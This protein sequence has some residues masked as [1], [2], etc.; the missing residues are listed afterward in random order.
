LFA[1]HDTANGIALGAGFASNPV[2]KAYEKPYSQGAL[3]DLIA[4]RKTI[5]E[6]LTTAR[7]ATARSAAAIDYLRP[8]VTN[9]G[10]FAREGRIV[11]T[12]PVRAD[13][14]AALRAL[15]ARENTGRH[16]KT[17]SL[18]TPEADRLVW[19]RTELTEISSKV[20]PPKP[21]QHAILADQPGLT[22]LRDGEILRVSTPL[23][24]RTLALLEPL[25]LIDADGTL[26]GRADTLPT[27]V[28]DGVIKEISAYH[29]GMLIP[30]TR[31][32]PGLDIAVAEMTALAR[33]SQATSHT[34]PHATPLARE[35]VEAIAT[36]LKAQF[37]SVAAVL[38]PSATAAMPPAA[39]RSL[40]AAASLIITQLGHG[41]RFVRADVAQVPLTQQPTITR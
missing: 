26:T 15:G 34:S 41:S 35:A 1:K 2:S 17:F 11:I 32:R 31:M 19:L 39:A 5:E 29:A 28:L 8:G 6:V 4:T 38:E 14:H 40:V 33:A 27:A 20:P 30:P 22:I 13:T 24:P 18:P 37:G 3:R 21:G 10:L 16:M 9:L 23:H 25:G 36:R 12:S 7:L